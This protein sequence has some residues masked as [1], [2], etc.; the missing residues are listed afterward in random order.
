MEEDSDSINKDA[1]DM[2]T[3][4][5]ILLKSKLDVA[6]EHVQKKNGEL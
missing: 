2:I 4:E 5:K 6:E 3:D 1:L